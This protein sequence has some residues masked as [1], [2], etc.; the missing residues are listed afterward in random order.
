VDEKTTFP[1]LQ[2]SCMVG[3][4]FVGAHPGGEQGGS[5]QPGCLFPGKKTNFCFE[6]N[7]PLQWGGPA[8]DAGG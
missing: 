6:W 4:V 8:R 3:A 7:N 5:F 2:A 1:E